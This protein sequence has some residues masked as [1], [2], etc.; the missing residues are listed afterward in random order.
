MINIPGLI[1]KINMMPNSKEKA[2]EICLLYSYINFLSDSKQITKEKTRELLLQINE[3]EVFIKHYATDDKMH[4]FSLLNSTSILNFLY[5][6]ILTYANNYSLF[7]VPIPMV[8]I[9]NLTSYA[10]NF[11]NSIDPELVKLFKKLMDNDFIVECDINNFGGKCHKLTGDLSGIIIRYDTSSFYKIMT[12]VHE[13]GHAYY[14][15]L[16]KC[17]PNLI[18]TNIANECI[19]RIFEQLFLVYLKENH[20]MNEN[21]IS[22]YE[23]FFTVHQLNIT[24][25]VYIVNKL[26]LDKE[27]NYD[28]YIDNIKANLLYQDYYDLSIIK[29]KT[30]EFQTYIAFNNNYYSYAYLLSMIIR[31]NYLEDKKETIKL[32]KDIPYLARDMDSFEFINMFDKNDYLSATKKNISRVLSKTY[33][34]K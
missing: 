28:F 25:S 21:D 22:K 33:Y 34:K 7:N 15:Y 32:I 23:R 16:N 2:L 29:P 27:I 1:K 6:D 20:L 14:N 24:N 18:R 30:N 17:S 8:N 12:V 5:K 19:P 10:I 9:S 31:E 3:V 4:V 11:L 13:M 26:L